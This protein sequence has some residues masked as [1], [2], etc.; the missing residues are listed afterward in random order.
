MEFPKNDVLKVMENVVFLKKYSIFSGV[1]TENIRA[2]AVIVK[3]ISLNN[4]DVIL[5]E[6]D[7]GE[8]FFILKKG[9]IRVTTGKDDKE[10]EIVKMSVGQIFGEMVLFEEHSLRS[11]NVYAN[12][13]NCV[14]LEISKEDLM[15]SIMDHP[16]IA[17]ELFKI[18]GERLTEMNKKLQELSSNAR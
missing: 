4:G 2:I 16:G 7:I 15:N 13:D 8:S 9:E 10:T 11:A 17:I 3:E 18:F 1:E 5:K 14:L 12:S 6:N